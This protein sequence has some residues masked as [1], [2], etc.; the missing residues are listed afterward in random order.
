VAH[1][2]RI[3]H[4]TGVI[5]GSE[6]DLVI[7]WPV[8]VNGEEIHVPKLLPGVAEY[9][10][11]ARAEG[12]A[13]TLWHEVF[14]H[15]DY[16]VG[17]PYPHDE[18]RAVQFFVTASTA[19]TT[20]AAGLESFA[21]HHLSRYCAPLVYDD[22]GNP[23][24]EATVNV[25]GNDYTFRELSFH[26]LDTRYRETLPE[27]MSVSRP[28]G[29]PWWSKLMQVQALAALQRHGIWDPMRRSGLSSP[30]KSL[31]QRYCDREYAGAAKMMLAAF[32]HFDPAWIKQARMSLL[33]PPP[34]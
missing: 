33:P 29:N 24:P 20:C 32:A 30:P 21:N 26:S 2:P 28:T 11:A 22:A 16:S 4:S 19:V 25:G 1:D 27:L 3:A 34:E 9:S 23:M 7:V 12:E 13:N 17:M 6:E 8:T 10:A 14:E 5:D 31:A 15:L 18:E